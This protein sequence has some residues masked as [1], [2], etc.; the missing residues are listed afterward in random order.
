MLKQDSLKTVM[1]TKRKI[2]FYS[3]IPL[4]SFKRLEDQ[5]LSLV[6]SSNEKSCNA[7]KTGNVNR[8]TM[9]S[10][11]S[12]LYCKGDFSVKFEAQVPMRFEKTMLLMNGRK[13][14]L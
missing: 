1:G 12:L 7:Q 9:K 2:I 11:S 13:E 3:H 6:R 8:L 5:T 4:P 10:E 14:I